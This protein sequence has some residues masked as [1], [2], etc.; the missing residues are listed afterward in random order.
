MM[1]QNPTFQP[2]A[3][4]LDA[5][6]K[7]AAELAQADLIFVQD[8]GLVPKRLVAPSRPATLPAA[9]RKWLGTDFSHVIISQ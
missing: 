3:S 2:Y 9:E 5:Q 6:S 8:L 7:G 1:K 4:L